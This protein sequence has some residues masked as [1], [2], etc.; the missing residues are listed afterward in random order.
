MNIRISAICLALITIW[1]QGCGTVR[2]T[3][4]LDTAITLNFNAREDI[5]PDVDGRTSPLVIR[6]F[7]LEDDR[8]IRR[9]EFLNLYEDA[10]GHLGNDLIDSLALKELAPGEERKETLELTPDIRF[11]ALMGEYVK[12][13]ESDTLL[14][15]PIE[16]HTHNKYSIDVKHLGLTENR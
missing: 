12:Y 6:V 14:I 11:V 4:N 1:L 10:K 15:I 16:A 3:L 8:Q 9:E 5:N 13:N 2:E 7:Y